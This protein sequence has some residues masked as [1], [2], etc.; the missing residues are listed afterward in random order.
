MRLFGW[1]RGTSGRTDP[2]ESGTDL[3]LWDGDTPFRV[4]GGRRRKAGIPYIVPWD[5]E[6]HNRLDF[7]HF[8]LRY[9]LHGNYAAPIGT[10]QSILD[11]GSGT[12]RW[13]IEMANL[14]AHASVVG[15]DISPPPVDLLGEKGMEMRPR[16][17]QFVLGNLLEG[18]PFPDNSFD[19]V[20]MRA[21]VTAIPH[22]RWQGVIDDLAL[23]TRPGGWV[24]S[25]EVTFLEG[26]GPAVNQ[27]MVW[28]DATLAL[29]NVVFMDGAEVGTVMRSS[30]LANVTVRRQAMPCGDSGG[31]A[32]K[33]L[34]TD[35]F[36]VLR[37]IGGMTVAQGVTTAEEF[38]HTME[39]AQRELADPRLRCTMP[40]YIAFGQRS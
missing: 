12:G 21:L 15:F 16:N 28:L 1:L 9:A 8:M 13:A 25:L 22:N 18:L 17:Y 40:L 36:T 3:A 38:D 31:R 32:G 33:M 34:A 19:Y 11:V 39:Q 23:V 7:Q 4:V 37:G 10:P 26:G 6:E 24:E 20:H 5:I 35:W 30:G 27:L 14:F 29:R 2:G